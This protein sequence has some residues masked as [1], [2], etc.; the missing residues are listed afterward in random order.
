MPT[1][2]LDQSNTTTNGSVIL[3]RSDG[4]IN[5][6]WGQSFLT[7][8][9]GTLDNIR[10]SLSKSGSPTGN[11]KIELYGGDATSPTGSV[12]STSANLDVSTITGSQVEYTLNFS[13]DYTLTNNTRYW[14]VISSNTTQ[15][16]SVCVNIWYNNLSSYANGINNRADDTTWQNDQNGDLYFKTYLIKTLSTGF[17]NFF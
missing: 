3:R 11:L 12:L 15:S 1:P 16:N 13:N 10:L 5:N 2:I 9:S 8:F 7:G 4:D 14:L 17:F 6:R